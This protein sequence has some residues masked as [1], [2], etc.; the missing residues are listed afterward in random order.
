MERPAAEGGLLLLRPGPGLTHTHTHT[1]THIIV[2]IIIIIII[3][4]ITETHMFTVNV[5]VSSALHWHAA[6]HRPAV[7]AA[8]H[9]SLLPGLHSGETSHKSRRFNQKL[10]L[11]HDHF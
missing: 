6:V 3:I 9:S 11:H 1:H 10:L 8:H 4:I 7:P 2:I 5:R